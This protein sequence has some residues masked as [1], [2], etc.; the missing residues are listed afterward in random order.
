V[1]IMAGTRHSPWL[2]DGSGRKPDA[3]DD[4]DNH[5]GDRTHHI[6]LSKELGS[7]HSQKALDNQ[8]QQEHEIEMPC[9]LDVAI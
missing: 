8:Q 9:L 1:Y 3:E 7:L 6:Q 5:V 2:V 4:E